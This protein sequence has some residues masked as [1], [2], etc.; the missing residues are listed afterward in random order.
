MPK[1]DIDAVPGRKGSSYPAP[2]HEMAKDRI[3]QALGNAGG[4]MDFGVNLVRLPPGAWSSQ[5]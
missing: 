5:V 2:F 1:I 4:L 3:K